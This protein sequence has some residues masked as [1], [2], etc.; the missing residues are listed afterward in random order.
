[1]SEHGVGLSDGQLLQ[2]RNPAQ[3]IGSEFNAVRKAPATGQVRFALCYPDLYTVGMS[4]VGSQILY[5]VLNNHPD[6]CCERAFLPDLDAVTALRSAGGRLCTLESGTPLSDLDVV[7]ITLQHELTYSTVLAL[8]DLGGIALPAAERGDSAPLVLGG[9]PCAYNPEPLAPFFDAFVIGDG[10]EAVIELAE[11]LRGHLDAPRQERLKALAQVPGVYVPALHDP[12]LDRITRRVVR[13]LDT[14]PH[15][16]RPVVPF[17]EVVHDR[18]QVELARGCT[19]GCRFCQAGV[20]YRPVR[21]RSP[22][23]VRRLARETIAHTGYDEVSV[24]SLNCPDYT[25]IEALLDGL[26][27]DLADQRVSI[28]LPS[29]RIDTF[30]VG[31]AQKVQRVRKSGLTFAP[32]AG[33]QRL[34]DVINKGVTE[35]DLLEAARAAFAAGWHTL[36][37]YFMIGLPTETDEDLQA[38]ADLVR[39]VARVG[40]ETMGNRAGRMRINV[41]ISTLVPKAFTP[42]QWEGQIPRAEILRRQG[43]L[44]GAIRDRQV[45]V[46]CHEAEGSVV[47]AALARGGRQTAQAILNAYRAGAVL[48]AWGEH[49]SYLRWER[50]FADAGMDLET[51]ATRTFDP[52]Q[53]LPWEHIDA[54]VSREFLLQERR[55]AL[56]EAALTADCRNGDCLGCGMRRLTGADGCPV[57]TETTDPPAPTASARP[58]ALSAS[59]APVRPYVM[60]RLARRGGA[61][62]LG[63]LDEARAMD[64]ALRRSGLPVAYSEGFNPRAKLSFGPPLP[65]GAESEAE[66]CALELTRPVAPEE[67]VR[68]LRPQMPPG[69]ELLTVVPGHRGR[70]SPLADLQWAEWEVTLAGAPATDVSRAVAD[71][72]DA[73]EVVVNRRTKSGEGPCDIRPGIEHLAIVGEEPVTV[74]MSLRLGPSNSAKPAEVVSALRARLGDGADLT[75]ERLKRTA[76]Y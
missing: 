18:A 6:A 36:K 16:T 47:E 55:R 75:V 28:G 51:E 70:R 60:L 30:S 72:L 15:P 42:F 4:H 41:S 2:V 44:R 69:L 40:R 66:L 21:E 32:E 46:A 10:E 27:A 61:R 23:T 49:F 9:G 35:E 14:A 65:V 22:Q 64:R 62:F 73:S 59:G 29:L 34:R 50:A 17:V 25:G 45:S 56:Q 8:L 54:G 1:M 11:A 37:L 63:H 33:S 43:H 58:P 7:G 74:Q 52:A 38:I 68:R 19:R 48:D 53:R 12:A 31:L 71:L 26:H 57:C 20:I 76:L 39:E 24:V 5:H 13:D 3:Y 67:I